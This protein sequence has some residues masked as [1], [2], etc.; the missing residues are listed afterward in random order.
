MWG[1]LKDKRKLTHLRDVFPSSHCSPNPKQRK[2]KTNGTETGNPPLVHWVRLKTP[3]F[4][5]NGPDWVQSWWATPEKAFEARMKQCPTP[6]LSSSASVSHL[7]LFPPRPD[8]RRAVIRQHLMQYWTQIMDP[9]RR[10]MEMQ[11]CGF[12]SMFTSCSQ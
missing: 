3:T 4:R 12:Y 9:R 7:C 8:R 6:P 10:E 1:K 11:L 2:N 5:L